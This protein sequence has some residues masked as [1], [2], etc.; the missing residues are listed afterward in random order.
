[1]P[2]ARQIKFRL[3]PEEDNL[4][5]RCALFNHWNRKLGSSPRSNL[6][7]V[8]KFEHFGAVSSFCN[9]DILRIT[10]HV[11]DASLATYAQIV[12]RNETPALEI[13]WMAKN[14]TIK[15]RTQDRK[16]ADY[17]AQLS[18]YKTTPLLNYYIREQQF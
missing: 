13:A 2:Y 3:G 16:R 1:M 12:I 11:L 7:P 18:K 6:Y 15:D 14:F 9:R 17:E 5:S 8:T 4:G 10:E